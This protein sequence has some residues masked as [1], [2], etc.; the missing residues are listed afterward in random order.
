[1]MSMI[2]HFFHWALDIVV[3][4]FNV[5]Q[6]LKVSWSNMMW[7][8][9]IEHQTNGNEKHNLS[10]YF[11]KKFDVRHS[12]HKVK[13]WHWNIIGWNKNAT[14]KTKIKSWKQG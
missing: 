4:K 6:Q 3:H 13:T 9:N 10:N 2:A 12:W 5:D 14:S 7:L 1:M 8:V 11:I